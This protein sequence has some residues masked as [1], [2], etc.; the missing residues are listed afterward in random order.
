MIVEG[1]ADKRVFETHTDSAKCIMWPAGGRQPVIDIL[2][3]AVRRKFTGILGIIDGDTDH[4]RQRSPSL[5]NLYHTDAWDSEGLMIRA[6][7]FEKFVAETKAAITAQSLRQKLLES[8]R[9]L[10]IVRCISDINSW[11]LRF[12]NVNY[13]IF[14]NSITLVCDNKKCLAHVHNLNQDRIS[15][16]LLE[17]AF[18]SSDVRQCDPWH[19]SRGH[20]MT[21]ILS[22]S[23]EN[24]LGVQMSKDLIERQLRLAFD[25][26]CLAQ[27]KLFASVNNWETENPPF[28]VWATQEGRSE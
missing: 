14:V 6:R 9:T 4:F 24:L 19:L 27:T 28:L 17:A 7:A 12:E 13:R 1:I 16:D 18:E 2:S 8:S 11:G 15:L 25:S 26:R 5:K 3:E 10:G 21:S 22:L 23:S 20:D